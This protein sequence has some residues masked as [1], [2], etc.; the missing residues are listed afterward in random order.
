MKMKYMEAFKKNRHSIQY[1]FIS[2]YFIRATQILQMT[3]AHKFLKNVRKYGIKMSWEDLESNILIN[4]EVKN[5]NSQLDSIDSFHATQ[6]GSVSGECI[7][8]LCK[9]SG[10]NKIRI[11]L[12]IV[13]NSKSLSTF[14][15]LRVLGAELCCVSRA[16]HVSSAD[17]LY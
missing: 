16:P 11:C 9:K 6:I 4:K 15:V 1:F 5:S 13:E 14:L 7:W 12:S 8:F 2:S 3:F 17:L 10:T